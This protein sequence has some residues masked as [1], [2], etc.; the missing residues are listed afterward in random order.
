MEEK[1]DKAFPKC[2]IPVILLATDEASN[3]YDTSLG[4]ENDATCSLELPLVPL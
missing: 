1:G 4:G 3:V 2:E